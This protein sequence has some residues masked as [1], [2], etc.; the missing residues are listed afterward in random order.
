MAPLQG[1]GSCRNGEGDGVWSQGAS[2]RDALCFSSA[3]LSVA[4]S[5]VGYVQAVALCM[6]CSASRKRSADLYV[7]LK[8][9][10]VQFLDVSGLTGS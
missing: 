2:G 3:L 4:L 8:N 5:R 9:P 7:S 6:R 1:S 10:Y